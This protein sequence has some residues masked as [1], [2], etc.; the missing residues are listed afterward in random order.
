LNLALP[1]HSDSGANRLR[2]ALHR[3]GSYVQS[4]QNFHLPAAVIK[5]CLL[6]HRS[7]HAAHAGRELGI[8]NVQFAIGRELA[9]VA[10]RAQVVGTRNFH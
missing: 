6:A 4:G 9:G 7:L 10:M 1:A 5:G 3:L 2:R 8:L